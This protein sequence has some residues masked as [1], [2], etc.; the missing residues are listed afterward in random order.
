MYSTFGNSALGY[1]Y[2]CLM[3][4]LVKEW[5]AL[6][7][8][9]PNT[10]DPM[11]PFG[12]VTLASSGNEGG[13]NL[14]SMRLAQTAGYGVLPNAAMPNTFLVQAL[15]LDDPYINTTCSDIKCCPCVIG[16]RA[17]MPSVTAPPFY[18]ELPPRPPPPHLQL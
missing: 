2:S 17:H 9:T 5:R 7:S 6:W 11:A 8:K 4:V 18:S 15:D 12:L 16:L 10:T 3:P 14:G 1:G 13:H